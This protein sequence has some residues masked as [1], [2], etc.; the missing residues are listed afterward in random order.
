MGKWL[1]CKK[2]IYVFL[3]D[4]AEETLELGESQ[5]HLRFLVVIAVYVR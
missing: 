3:A 5:K 1:D 4:N 2:F